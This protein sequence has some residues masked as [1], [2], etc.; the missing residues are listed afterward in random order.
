MSIPDEKQLW[1]ILK[2]HFDTYGFVSHQIDTYNDFVEN[3][4]HNI[5]T[6]EPPIVIDASDET[7]NDGDLIG[8]NYPL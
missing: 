1:N 7:L 3:G 2:N 4:I 5:I 6:N 8:T